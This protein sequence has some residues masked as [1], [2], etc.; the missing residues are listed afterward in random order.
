MIIPCRKGLGLPGYEIRML[1]YGSDFRYD[2]HGNA[3]LISYFQ[4]MV[5]QFPA[6]FFND[7]IEK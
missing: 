6:V 3:S 5:P 7:F 2:T 1:A 4:K